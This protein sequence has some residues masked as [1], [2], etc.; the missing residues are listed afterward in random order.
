MINPTNTLAPLF[1][2][3]CFVFCVFSLAACAEKQKPTTPTAAAPSPDQNAEHNALI[4]DLATDPCAI[5]MQDTAGA[6]AIFYHENQGFPQNLN[7]IRPYA[8]KYHLNVGDF[9]CPASHEPYV[10]VPSGLSVPGQVRRLVLYDKSPIHKGWRWGIVM[11]PPPPGM[12]IVTPEVIRLSQDVL[13]LY[14]K[15]APAPAH[16]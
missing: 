15:S 8:K 11:S 12:V 10:Y 14:L 1:R 4:I 3:S 6:L 2:V 9:T 13:D 5:R 7:A 16:P